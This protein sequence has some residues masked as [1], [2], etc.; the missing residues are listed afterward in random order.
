MPS[1]EYRELM[2]DEIKELLPIMR[3]YSEDLGHNYLDMLS[4][5]YTIITPH[6]NLA[7]PN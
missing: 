6:K 5:R 7:E 3:E 2:D 1:Y 4:D